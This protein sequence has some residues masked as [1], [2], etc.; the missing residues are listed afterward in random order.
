MKKTVK[1]LNKFE[2]IL[3]ITAT[4]LSVVSLIVFDDAN[5]LGVIAVISGVISVVL[6]AKGHIGYYFFGIINIVAYIIIGYIAS[7]YGEVML[8]TLYYLP[9]QFVGLYFWKKNLNKEEKI[10]KAA[11]LKRL[12]KKAGALK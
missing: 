12:F 11:F 6:A 4:I 1:V 2:W 3:I 8:N 9:M 10:V 5:I 7:L